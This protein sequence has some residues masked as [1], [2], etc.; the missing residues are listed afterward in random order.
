MP[1][2]RSALRAGLLVAA[3]GI[4][5]CA[6]DAWKSDPGFNGW[7]NRVTQECYPRSIGGAQFTQLFMNP[8]FLDYASRL[9]SGKID[10]QQ[11]RDAVNSFYPGD[12]QAGI[13][14]LVAKLPPTVGPK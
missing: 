12:N 1:P 13:D 11:F 9:Y 10:A 8:S 2:A 3:A 7:T 14:C 6:P 5:A 4:T